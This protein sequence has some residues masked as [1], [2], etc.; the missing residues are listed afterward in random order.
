MGTPVSQPLFGD[1]IDLAQPRLGSEVVF[2]TDDFFADKSRLI[3]P[4]EPV[5]IDDKYDDYGKWMDGW[6]SRRKRDEGHDYCIVKLGVPGVIFGVVVDTRF[7]TGNFPPHASLEAC[8]SHDKIPDDSTDWV[9]IVSKQALK[10]DNRQHFRVENDTQFTHVRLHI[11]P[12]GGIARL[13]IY[14]EI[15]P[16]WSRFDPLVPIDL[17][18]LQHGGRALACN[19]E[20]YGSMRNL[21]A[22]G[23]G[24][25]MGDGW[26]TARRRTPGND[27]VVMALGHPGTIEAIEVDTAHFKGNYPDRVMLQATLVPAG[28][29]PDID[30]SDQW[31]ILLGEHKLSMDT[32]HYFI[33]DI[34]D[35]GPISHVRMN[36]YPDGGI[37]RLRII[38]R[39]Y[40]PTD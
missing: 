6:E 35:I 16:D 5:W 24:V 38:G 39:L 37:S 12:D 13:R 18:S 34:N 7:F 4:G 40:Q 3:S 21:N 11:Y 22:P 25:N 15:Q 14:G 28:E 9:E 29:S 33:D 8:V 17:L 19:D 26:E 31:P 32:Q 20:H 23:R 27:W 10:G 1:A 2:A 36:I 30:S